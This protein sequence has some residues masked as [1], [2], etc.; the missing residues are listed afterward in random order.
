MNPIA[1]L[2]LINA[3]GGAIFV[4]TTDPNVLTNRRRLRTWSEAAYK[5]IKKIN[6]TDTGILCD[7]ECR[8]AQELQQRDYRIYFAEPIP[9]KKYAAV[10]VEGDSYKHKH[11]HDSVLVLDPFPGA[12]FGHPI[13]AFYVDI[14]TNG[15]YCDAAKGFMIGKC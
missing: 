3:V 7:R 6:C 14:N 15:S 13:V 4:S 10:F 1:F 5:W 11:G 8:T 12:R 9:G 2:L